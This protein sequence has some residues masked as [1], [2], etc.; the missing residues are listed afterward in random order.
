M[1]SYDECLLYDDDCLL[2]NCL[3]WWVSA[4]WWWLSAMMIVRYDDWRVSEMMIV[5][6]I[7]W[8]L[9][10][11]WLSGVRYLI[12][13]LMSVCWVCYDYDCLLCRVSDMIILLWW[14]LSAMIVCFII[15]CY[16]IVCYEGYLL[17]WLSAM[18]IVCY[19]DCLHVS[20]LVVFRLQAL[21]L[22]SPKTSEQSRPADPTNER[23][24]LWHHSPLVGRGLCKRPNSLSYSVLL[25]K[26]LPKLCL[27]SSDI[28]LL[29]VLY[30]VLI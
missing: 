8:W 26:Y 16:I 1:I 6:M 11:I 10:A 5:C 23:R 25:F 15:V 4:I 30:F 19:D 12:A 2:Y 14:W 17:W 24:D 22:L 20:L 27:D 9:S 18:M 21:C 13:A 29:G 7:W 28:R 3:L